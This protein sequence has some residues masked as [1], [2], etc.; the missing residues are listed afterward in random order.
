MYYNHTFPLRPQTVKLIR[1]LIA[2][3][4]DY[5]LVTNPEYNTISS[6]LSYIAKYGKPMPIITQ[7]LISGREAAEMLSIS[8]S[9]FRALEREGTFPFKRRLLGNKT[10][11][12]KNTDIFEYMDVCSVTQDGQPAPGTSESPQAEI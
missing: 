4:M 3:L 6:Q 7:K 5:G 8:Y 10:V 12:Y 2:P 9:Q 11:R 1:R